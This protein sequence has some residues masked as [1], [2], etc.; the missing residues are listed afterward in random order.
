MTTQRIFFMY[1]YF[2][3]HTETNPLVS[4]QY[5]KKAVHPTGTGRSPGQNPRPKSPASSQ[6]P[7]H[8][9]LDLHSVYCM[10]DVRPDYDSVDSSEEET[11]SKKLRADDST[12]SLPSITIFDR[13]TILKLPTKRPEREVNL[14]F[15][16]CPSAPRS[17]P[18]YSVSSYSTTSPQRLNPPFLLQSSP[19]SR[20]RLLTPGIRRPP[21]KQPFS[22]PDWVNPTLDAEI[23]LNDNGARAEPIY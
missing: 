1:R 12:F 7:F 20:C 14:K 9:K 16:S 18:L 4:K 5:T 22:L 8:D 3:H 6:G 13:P 15:P 17:R 11:V 10:T 21:S 23:F 19:I 2:H